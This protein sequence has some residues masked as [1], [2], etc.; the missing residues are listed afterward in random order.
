MLTDQ[1]KKVT[2]DIMDINKFYGGSCYDA[3]NELGAHIGKNSVTFRTYAP[4]ALK[5][6]VIG[7]FSD[8]EEI[9]M[10]RSEDGAFF[11]VTTKKAHEGDRYKYRIYDKDGKFLDH[12]DPYGFG[13]EVRPGTCS[14]IR[15]ISEYEFTDGE[16]MSRRTVGFDKPLNIYE[17]HLGSW[18]CP[19][20]EDGDW[21][22]YREIAPLLVDYLT[23]FGF[24]CVEF[25][26]LSEHPADESWG[27]Q[28]T[29]FFSPT[30]RYGKPSDLQ[31]LVDS[32]HN[33]G[34]S[35]ILDFVPVHFAVND[36][37]LYKYD[38]THLYEYP[39]ADIGYNE[40]GSCNFMHA[41][42]DVRSFLQS[43]AEYWLK[44]YHFDGLRID[45]VRNLIYWQG[46]EGRGV[47][48]DAV[49][50]I[51]G[52]NSGIKSRYPNVMMIAEDSSDYG[53]VTKSIS[54][55]GLGFDYKWDL[56]WMHDTLEYMQSS[57]IYRTRDYHKLTFS[58][59]YFYN[60]RYVLPLSHDE[61][62]HGKATIVQKMN[63]QYDDKFPQAKALYMYMIAH[64][65][66]KLNFMGSEFGQLR[67]W[68]EKRQQDWDMLKYPL[69]DSFREYVKTLN[70]IY[71]THSAL[72]YDYDPTNFMWDDCKSAD[73]CIYAVRRKSADGDILAVINMSDWFQS[74]YTV[75]VGEGYEVTLL[76]DSDWQKFNGR[77]KEGST[78]FNYYKDHI[79]MN[80]PPFS[81]RLFSLEKTK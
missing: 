21:Y 3:Y 31:F 44:E 35:V 61:V 34:I 22:T 63:G 72:Y 26:P 41:H 15:S 47:N 75:K 6:S 49:R 13:A 46:E 7:D 23:D 29:G 60:E 66:K 59:L 73:R 38:G 80:I 18:K 69:H 37:A 76:V 55:N 79:D 39:S 1:I 25:M 64:P 20:D 65:G 58:M 9:P 50:F 28:S 5:V 68:D 71:L 12:C 78:D 32:L 77:T 74:N 56:G 81:A 51:Q 36:Y 14:V 43:A 57:P 53:G 40:W 48:L 11:S 54:E 70:E 2:G 24:N 10:K 33:A 62:V 42:G 16:W 27:Y 8:W 45:A 4:N 17:M 19:S 67:E 30:S 52:L